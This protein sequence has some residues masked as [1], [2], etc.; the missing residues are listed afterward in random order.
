[1]ESANVLTICYNWITLEIGCKFE[2]IR[3]NGPEIEIWHVFDLY[4]EKHI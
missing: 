1:M 2:V 4:S 3:S